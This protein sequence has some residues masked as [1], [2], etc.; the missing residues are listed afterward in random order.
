[1]NMQ[2][3]KAQVDFASANR[4]I[5]LIAGHDTSVC[6]RLI[7]DSDKSKAAI[8]L[9]GTLSEHWKR[10]K[11]AQR[12]GYG[13]FMVV[14]EG[15]NKDVEITKIRAVF[16]DAD[17]RPLPSSWHIQP[18]FIVRRDANHWHAYWIVREGTVADFP[19]LQ[20]RLAAFYRTDAMVSNKS[21]VMRIPGF[22]HQKGT[23]T[24]VMLDDP[25]SGMDTCLLGAGMEELAAGLPELSA[26]LRASL[27]DREGRPITLACLKE[28]LRR[29]DP[30]CSRTKWLAVGG[31]LKHAE[32]HKLVTLPDL[33]I[34][35]PSFNGP[36]MF[37][38]WSAG[39]L[40]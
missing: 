35:D 39:E 12:E 30:G 1:M 37:S 17:N 14:N 25:S 31:A 18:N 7:H 32:A 28:K 38:K 19:V 13:V 2:E 36:R 6:F 4:F 26:P 23:P 9:F 27:G 15:G 8:T 29:I 33:Q 34:P 21:R 5:E 3:T 24:P 10:I 16:I 11:T 20:K 22:L 40:Q